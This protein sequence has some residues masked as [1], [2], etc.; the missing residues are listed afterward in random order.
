MIMEVAV[1]YHKLKY[2]NV[3]TLKQREDKYSRF[4]YSKTS[5][6]IPSGLVGIEG[7]IKDCR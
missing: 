5:I 2:Q 1:M 4:D 7:N 6:N 3:S